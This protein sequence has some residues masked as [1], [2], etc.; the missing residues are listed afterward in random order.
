MTP[1]RARPNGAR[2]AYL[3]AWITAQARRAP[4]LPVGWVT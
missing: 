3:A 1:A 4:E 2:L